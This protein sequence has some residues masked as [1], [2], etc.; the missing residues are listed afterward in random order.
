MA[1]GPMETERIALSQRERDRL[2]VLHDVREVH[3]TQVEAAQRLLV[4]KRIVV[5]VLEPKFISG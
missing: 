4:Q 3:L 2:K 1:G 5:S